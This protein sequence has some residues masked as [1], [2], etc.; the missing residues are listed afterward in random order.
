MSNQVKSLERSF[1]NSWSP[2]ILGHFKSKLIAIAL[3]LLTREKS[4]ILRAA[5]FRAKLMNALRSSRPEFP[6]ASTADFS[7]W[8]FN[9]RSPNSTRLPFVLPV[10]IDYS[11]TR[12]YQ[13]AFKLIPSNWQTS[14]CFSETIR[15]REFREKSQIS[16][17]A[18]KRKCGAGIRELSVARYLPLITH[19]R[20]AIQRGAA[21]SCARYKNSR[22]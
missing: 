3:Y 14:V 2:A 10:L 7:L 21:A 19:A 12:A 6:G 22:L 5:A 4:T 1:C 13:S 15:S 8:K 16:R 20:H 9:H 11:A 17:Q 18:R